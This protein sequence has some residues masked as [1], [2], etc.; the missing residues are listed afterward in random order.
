MSKRVVITGAG[1]W[2][3]LGTN[4]EAVKESL[5]N[6]KSGIGL[7][8]DRLDYGY[9][10]G[11]TGIVER[12]QLKGLLELRDGNNKEFFDSKLKEDT[13][14]GATSMAWPQF[15]QNRAPSG[16]MFPQL[17]HLIGSI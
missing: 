16:T 6:G 3:C 14:A 7:D 17:G 9:R 2:S 10:S 15:I 4:M 5:Y 11:L 12:P 13:A 8:Q 1:I